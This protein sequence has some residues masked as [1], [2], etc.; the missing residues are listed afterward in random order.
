MSLSLLCYQAHVHS[1]FYYHVH[2][3]CKIVNKQTNFIIIVEISQT[4]KAEVTFVCVYLKY[5]SNNV[6]HHRNKQ[7]HRL[8]LICSVCTIDVCLCVCQ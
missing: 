8:N 4:N 1:L 5:S 3:Q 6:N 7:K 2:A